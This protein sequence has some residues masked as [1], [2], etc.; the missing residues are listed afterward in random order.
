MGVFSQGF[1]NTYTVRL[2]LTVLGMILI[3]NQYYQYIN[4]IDDI[5]IDIDIDDYGNE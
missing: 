3:L 2:I 4:I 1:D 5:D